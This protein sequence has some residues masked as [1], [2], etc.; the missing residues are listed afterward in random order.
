MKQRI[1]FLMLLMASA[2]LWA[3]SFTVTPNDSLFESIS[4]RGQ[5]NL[6]IY[7]PNTSGASQRLRWNVPSSS[8]PLGWTVQVC[9]NF[10][11][12]NAPHPEVDSM[13]A[14]APLDSGFIKAT[15][16]PFEIPGSGWAKCVVW[17]VAD[18]AGTA[19]QLYFAVDAVPTAVNPLVLDDQYSLSPIPASDVLHLRAKNGALDKGVVKLYD[20]KG[21]IVL[22]S[23]ISTVQSADFDVSELS[24]GIYMMR[25]ES[26]VGTMTKKVVVAH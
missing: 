18:S 21:Q 8:A 22:Q 20:I 15:F 13:M 23:S 10:S 25:Y 7:F 3:Q 12:H 26:K 16:T 1:L 2:S 17:D 6:T 4:P 24:P 5:A 14:V 9:D 19:V 11:C